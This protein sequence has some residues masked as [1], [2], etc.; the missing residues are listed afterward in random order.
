M[1][2]IHMVVYGHV[3][4]GAIVPDTGITW[5]DGARATITLCAAPVASIDRMSASEQRRYLDAL[6]G[7]DAIEDE[8]PGDDTGGTDHERILH[9]KTT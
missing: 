3:E 4:N 9:G 1:Y 8:N 5:P 2:D 6:G 7:I